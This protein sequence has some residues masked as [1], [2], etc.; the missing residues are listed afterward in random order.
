MDQRVLLLAG[1]FYAGLCLRSSHH[2]QAYLPRYV[3]DMQARDVALKM[4]V[5]AMSGA[6]VLV[7]FPDGTC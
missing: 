5:E 4:H 2:M 7:R 1:F 6:A 3:L